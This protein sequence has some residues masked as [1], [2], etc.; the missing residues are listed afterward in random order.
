MIIIIKI[1]RSTSMHE[2]S[3]SAKEHYPNARALTHVHI[4]IHTYANSYATLDLH[5]TRAYAAGE[6]ILT[7]TIS[8]PF[9]ECPSCKSQHQNR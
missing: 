5:V 6:I 3:E 1:V 4:H 2:Q 7:I 9:I 8:Q